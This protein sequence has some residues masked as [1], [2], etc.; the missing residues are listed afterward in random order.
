MRRLF[1]IL[2]LLFCIISVFSQTTTTYSCKYYSFSYPQGWKLEKPSNPSLLVTDASEMVIVKQGNSGAT[3]IAL[4][5]YNPEFKIS[6][7]TINDLNNLKKGIQSED[8]TVVF[9][10]NPIVTTIKGQPCI[11]MSYTSYIAGIK[12]LTI[13]YAFKQSKYVYRISGMARANNA[14]EKQ[15]V[16]NSLNSFSIINNSSATQKNNS[17]VQKNETN[18]GR[19]NASPNYSFVDLGLSVKWATC[20]VGAKNS[21]DYGGYYFEA[22]AVKLQN[23]ICR[24]PTEKEIWELLKNC[25]WEWKGNGYKV[26]GKNGNTI[27]L[28]ASGYRDLDWGMV[29]LGSEGYFW[30]ST[31]FN[32]VTAFLDF[33]KERQFI[34][35]GLGG[36][37]LSVRF[38]KK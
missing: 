3:I 29:G 27:F 35:G 23:S 30:S 10:Q 2:L 15:Q 22:E 4:L 36:S 28:P 25:Q 6:E 13:S 12:F 38:V 8:R 21:T 7:I 9:T 16:L 18:K 32:G 34:N 14:N 26:T 31:E 20:N 17:A 37:M 11:K 33:D 19:N 5:E 24:L 1:A